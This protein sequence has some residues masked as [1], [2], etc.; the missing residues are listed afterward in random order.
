[1]PGLSKDERAPAFPIDPAK[2]S[3]VSTRRRSDKRQ[4][5]DQPHIGDALRSVY[6]QTMNEVVPAEMLDLLGRLD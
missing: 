6:D 4:I 3:P 2:V 5:G 1:M